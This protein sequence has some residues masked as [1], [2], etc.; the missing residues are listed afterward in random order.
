MEG[1]QGQARPPGKLR[2]PA[3]GTTLA[4]LAV[5]CVAAPV[6]SEVYRWVDADGRVQY[7]DQPPAGAGA[8]RVEVGAEKS[9]SGDLEERRERREKFLDVMEEE[10]E[11]DARTDAEKS[12][13]E[14]KR[15]QNCSTATERLRQ[16]EEARYI[17]ERSADPDNPRVL[18]DP[19]RDAYTK[20]A[21]QDVAK[22]CP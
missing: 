1:R 20:R 8:E 6:S 17:Y 21:R 16:I 14:T 22:W 9:V 5:L 18:D 13:Q 4:L 19:E 3:A 10:R 7:G 2:S 11:Q 12:K 15:R